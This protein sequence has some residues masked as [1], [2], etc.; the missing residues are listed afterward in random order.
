M[1]AAAA[2]ASVRAAISTEVSCASC[3]AIQ[4]PA[5]AAEAPSLDQFCSMIPRVVPGDTDFQPCS[6]VLFEIPFLFKSAKSTVA[7]ACNKK[8]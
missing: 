2:L 5:V 4:C 6:S 3:D 1:T 8:P 7:I